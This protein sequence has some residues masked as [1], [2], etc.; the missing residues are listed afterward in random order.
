MPRR[1]SRRLLFAAPLLS[2]PG[3][4]AVPRRAAA[5]DF[6]AFLDAVRRE[7]VGQGIRPLTVDQ[8]LG[9]AQYLPHVIELD[10][11]QP[12]QILTFLQYLQK[13]VTPQRKESARRALFNNRALLDT[14]S[15]RFDV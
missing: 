4:L 13:T 8:A 15:R 2:A 12:E 9:F 11:R 10:R 5:S 14:V 7:A 1:Y 3:L 6:A